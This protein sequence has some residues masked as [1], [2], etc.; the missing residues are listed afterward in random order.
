MTYVPHRQVRFNLYLFH[1]HFSIYLYSSSQHLF[2]IP[3]VVI[4]IQNLVDFNQTITY[5]SHQSQPNDCLILNI[6]TVLKT[7]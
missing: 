7:D 3:F 2:Q 6:E 5:Y 1:Y 4:Q